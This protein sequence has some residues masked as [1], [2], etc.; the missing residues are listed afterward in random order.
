MTSIIMRSALLAWGKT[1]PPEL[2]SIV[3]G[4]VVTWAEV[5]ER[6]RKWQRELLQRKREGAPAWRAYRL[7]VLYFDMDLMGGWQSFIE[8]FR[9]RGW[10][11]WIDRD[12]RQLKP[13]LMDLFPLILSGG[14]KWEIWKQSFAE[15]FMRRLHDG[16]PSGVCNLWWN[17]RD[18]PRI[19]AERRRNGQA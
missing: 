16:R 19:A 1:P 11:T 17:G 12:S 7:S 14:N 5:M 2:A 3:D 10:S 18:K 15:Q 9:G 6:R 8:D 13:V 4:R